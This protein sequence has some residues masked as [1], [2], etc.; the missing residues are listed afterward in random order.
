[1]REDEKKYYV[2]EQLDDNDFEKEKVEEK[3]ARKN[4]KFEMNK[5]Q[6]T[7][8]ISLVLVIALIGIG[9]YLYLNPIQ[10]KSTAPEQFAKDFC[11]YF[12]SGNWNKLNNLLDFKG[13]YILGYVLDEKDYT[14]FD[15]T[16]SSFNEKDKQYAEY[17]ESVKYLLNTNIER[18]YRYENKHK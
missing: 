15:K 17:S 8:I 18:Y 13:F 3:I 5:K 9:I 7:K 4:K 2:P 12:N 16:Y 14:K 1:M 6:V 10:K 11:S